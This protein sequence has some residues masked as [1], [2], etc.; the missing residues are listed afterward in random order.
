[1]LILFALP[2][3][4]VKQGQEHQ[5]EQQGQN[6]E[7]VDISATTTGHDR[8][9]RL[10]SNTAA[11]I[12]TPHQREKSSS[13]VTK[14]L[15]ICLVDPPRVLLYLQFPAVA[16]VVY[17][18]AITFGSLYVLNISIESAFSEAPYNFS[19]LIIGL[20]YIPSSLGY[21]AASLLGGPWVDRIMVREATKAGRFE[22][23]VDVDG[24]TRQKLIYLP[25]DRMRENV[26]ISATLYPAALI[27]YGWAVQYKLHWM[28][29]AVA[30]F[31]YG[32]GSMLVFSATTT[33]LT[34]FMPNRSSSGVALNNL[35]RNVFS[36]V[37]LVIGQPLIDQIGHGWLMTLVGL[38]A[39]LSGNLCMWT[40]RRNSAK[41]RVRMDRK[42]SSHNM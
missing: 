37:G 26:W 20:L 10:S 7:N 13:T 8:D 2:E 18:A 38:L 17:Y 40:L 30:T 11:S 29:S 39:C 16:I 21:V 23:D 19:A 33:M 1:L 9:E 42:L 3:T 27:W 36:C 25:E 14:W 24:Q 41:W 28:V 32:A 5:R 31:F 22:V 6:R 34:E 12:N 15:R 4:L 35:V